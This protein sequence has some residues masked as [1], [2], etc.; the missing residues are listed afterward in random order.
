MGSAG[1]FRVLEAT[2]N[3]GGRVG[4]TRR[5]KRSTEDNVA[6]KTTVACGS[7]V[8]GVS[9]GVLLLGRAGGAP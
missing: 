8:S 3:L 6:Q 7:T 9:A 2:R 4:L 5:T 1:S